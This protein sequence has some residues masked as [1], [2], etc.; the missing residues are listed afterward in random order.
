LINLTNNEQQ[1]K[2]FE[3]NLSGNYTNLLTNQPIQLTAQQQ[4]TLPIYGFMV[5]KAD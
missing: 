1:F 2:L 5:L 3:T 4:M